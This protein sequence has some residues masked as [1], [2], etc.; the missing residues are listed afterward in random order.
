MTAT[1][2]TTT[3]HVEFAGRVNRLHE[4]YIVV[5]P[6]HEMFSVEYVRS[7]GEEAVGRGLYANLGTAISV[8]RQTGASYRADAAWFGR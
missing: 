3:L 4:A 7:D 1:T 8:A 2:Q 6:V 5:V